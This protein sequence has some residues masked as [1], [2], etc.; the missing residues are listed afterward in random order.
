[1]VLKFRPVG[2]TSHGIALLQSGW[3]LQE[4]PNMVLVGVSRTLLV[5]VQLLVFSFSVVFLMLIS[6][7]HIC[8]RVDGAGVGW[9][10]FPCLSTHWLCVRVFMWA[11][12]YVFIC[13][14]VYV[15]F[16]VCM[17][18]PVVE[19]SGNV[20]PYLTHTAQVYMIK[21]IT[22]SSLYY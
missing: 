21:V 13:L 14:S 20:H 1:M 2:F 17:C 8:V 12:M 19:H 10:G 6:L 18:V 11:C 15:C 16:S 3:P 9:G 4:R 5:I 22:L 7:M